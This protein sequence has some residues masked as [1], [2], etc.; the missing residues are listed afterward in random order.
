M[1]F[2]QI[3]LITNWKSIYKIELKIYIYHTLKAIAF[4][5]LRFNIKISVRNYKLGEKTKKGN[6]KKKKNP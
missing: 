4:E 1:N 2:L 6:R 3:L 5:Q